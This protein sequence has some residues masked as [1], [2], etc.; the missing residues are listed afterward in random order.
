MRQKKQDLVEKATRLYKDIYRFAYS[1]TKDY[2]AA[3]DIA[4]TVMEAAISKIDSLRNPQVLKQWI[5][6]I[7]ANEINGFFF[8][9]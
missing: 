1:R 2:E 9:K 8:G 6:Q 5:M 7:T 3:Q 4:Q